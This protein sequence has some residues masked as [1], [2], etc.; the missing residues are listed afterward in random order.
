M[1]NT[2]KGK[3]QAP[4][5]ANPGTGPV[6]SGQVTKPPSKKVQTALKHLSTLTPA[7]RAEL[8]G[9][10]NPPPSGAANQAPVEVLDNAN[11]DAEM[12]DAEQGE[13][14]GK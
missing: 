6:K 8:A 14:A 5:P 10:I 9:F 12:V 1:P 3:K 11:N 7:E 2:R 4:Q 13:G